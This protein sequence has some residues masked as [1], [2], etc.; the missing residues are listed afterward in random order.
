LSTVYGIVTQQGGWVDCRSGLGEGTTFDVYLPVVAPGAKLEA[1]P[2]RVAPMAGTETVLLAD[3]EE[4]LRAI[5]KA[6]LRANGYDVLTAVD[7]ADALD[8]FARRRG[9]VDLVL[10][11]LSM[12]ALSGWEVMDRMLAIDPDVKI[13]VCSGYPVD[14]GESGKAMATV[15]KPFDLVDLLQTVRRVLDS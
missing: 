13:V 9:E 11:D 1:P 2:A 10:L 12:P 5:G 4:E 3:D 8:T 7:G 14:L 6:I 15:A